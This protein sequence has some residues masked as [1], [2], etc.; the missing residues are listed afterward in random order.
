MYASP[1]SPKAKPLHPALSPAHRHTPQIAGRKHT[2]R[3]NISKRECQ[4][5]SH[6]LRIE[7]GKETHQSYIG[8]HV[9]LESHIFNQ[10]SV[11]NIHTDATNVAFYLRKTITKKINKKNRIFV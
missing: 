5:L 7:I 11:N 1:G 2:K 10:Q 3:D 6:F 4:T 9:A 8:F